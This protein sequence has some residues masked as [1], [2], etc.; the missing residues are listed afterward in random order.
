MYVYMYKDIWRVS[1]V[2]LK[3]G[4]CERVDVRESD[5]MY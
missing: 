2:K 5:W 4:D 1:E 3:E